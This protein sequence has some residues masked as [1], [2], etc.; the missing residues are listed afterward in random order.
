[1]KLVG[2]GRLFRRVIHSLFAE[3]IVEPSRRQR[4]SLLKVMLL[5]SL[6]QYLKTHGGKA[7]TPCALPRDKLTLRNAFVTDATVLLTADK[8][9]NPA[10]FKDLICLHPGGEA[11]RERVLCSFTTIRPQKINGAALLDQT[12]TIGGS[13][14]DDDGDTVVENVDWDAE[15]E[16][17]LATIPK[18]TRKRQAVDTNAAAA[19]K[20]S[21]A[22]QPK[23][24]KSNRRPGRRQERAEQLVSSDD[25]TVADTQHT[26]DTEAD[27][28]IE[29][30]L[31][32]QDLQAALD[33]GDICGTDR[34]FG[35]HRQ[36]SC[37]KSY[38]GEQGN[39]SPLSLSHI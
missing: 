10:P 16:A 9:P 26:I 21:R 19:S 17:L 35:S 24:G 30:Q 25:V 39:G 34:P 5:A 22:A 4:T 11:Q 12:N 1:V 27:V 7:P 31:V 6:R 20:T 23:R 36:F 37:S 18:N 3:I 38:L 13:D 8:Q 2:F 28:N 33:A 14:D 29:D 32:V 15:L